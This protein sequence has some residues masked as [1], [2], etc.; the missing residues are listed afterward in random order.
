[1]GRI[2]GVFKGT[3][4]ALKRPL[5]V[6]LILE[7]IDFVL[8][9]VLCLI[10]VQNN[11][12]VSAG[13]I[14]TVFLVVMALVIP[15]YFFKRILNLGATRRDYY[16]GSMFTYSIISAIF[17]L[18]NI[19]WLSLE[20]GLLN[21]LRLHYNIITIFGWDRYGVLGM[22]FYQ[23]AAYL[24]LIAF[25]NLVVSSL[26][27]ILGIIMNFLLVA[28]IAVSLSI[29]TL[30]IGVIKSLK[31]LIFNPDILTGFILTLVLS[32]ILFG[33]GWYFTKRREIYV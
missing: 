10:G 22:F 15:L 30:R 28:A 29:Q 1:M 19:I 16:L 14:V 31:I 11:N 5:Q 20:R 17:S 2:I 8:D 9:M 3:L 27:N 7:G 24:L 33:I 6:I 23:L 32:I 21:Q 12:E 25:L 13:N 26:K 18:F 4:I